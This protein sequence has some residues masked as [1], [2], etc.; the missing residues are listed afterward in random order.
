MQLSPRRL[1]FGTSTA[2]V[3]AAIGASMLATRVTSTL[4]AQRQAKQ[5]VVRLES[6]MAHDDDTRVLALSYLERA[7]LGLGSPFR[8]IDQAVHDPR[9]AD[10]TRRDIAWAIVDR[11]FDGR[12]YEI[13]ARVLDVM[14]H[15]GS[16]AGHLDVI[17]QVIRRS[18]DPRVGEAAVRIA[19]G[20]AASNGSTS[21]TSLPVVAEVAAQVRD[22]ALAVRDLRHAVSRARERGL[23][24]IDELMAAR[25]RRALLVEQPLLGVLSA[26]DREAAIDMTPAILARI[27]A[28]RPAV[29]DEVSTT[30]LDKKSAMTLARLATAQPPLAAIRVPVTGRAATLR[31]DSTL[32]RSALSVIA[33]ATNEESLVAAYAFGDAA[34]ESPSPTLRRLMVSA[35]VALRAHAQDPVWLGA[36]EMTPGSVIGRYALKSITFDR[37]I[38]QTW[39]PF[40]TRMIAGALDD[41]TRVLPGYDPAGLSF[42]VEMGPLPD[43]ALAMHDPRTHTIRLSAMTP[44]GTLAHELAHDVD[45]RAA[46]TLFAKSG[47]YATDRSVREQSLRLSS[48]VRGLTQA[49]IAGRGRISPHGSSRPAEFFARNVDWFVADGLASMGRS[50]GFLSAIEDPVLTGFATA[51]ADAPSLE[52]ARALIGTLAEMTYVPDSSGRAYVKRWSSLDLLDPSALVLRTM[53]APVISRRGAR[54]F[55]GVPREIA[56]EL[57][58][59]MLCQVASLRAGSSQ[60]RLMAMAIDARAKG[61]IARRARYTP[62]LARAAVDPRPTLAAVAE[63]FA[64]IGLI[65]LTPAPFRPRCD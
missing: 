62:A 46:R 36:E 17:E 10:S 60:Q 51:P 37:R 27:E 63:G 34:G 50:N 61:I 47:G 7:R 32:A 35:A 8:L 3:L 55:F 59:G 1:F 15:A 6:A 54:P 26:G 19:Y 11:I 14:S 9:I 21:L 40:Y 65:E 24:V 44:S 42:M 5:A 2:L 45:W 25:S 22:G 23:D 4:S 41:F 16:G 58:T 18:D 49:R 28:V 38:P 39:R 30:L 64:R 13:D 52:T 57:S 53:D 12:I 48:S 56:T 33:A 29:S 43:S 31:A 20:L